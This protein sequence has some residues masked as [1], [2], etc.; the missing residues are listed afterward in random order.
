MLVGRLKPYDLPDPLCRVCLSRDW[1][2]MHLI[3]QAMFLPLTLVTID[4]MQLTHMFWSLTALCNVQLNAIHVVKF[5]R[6][7]NP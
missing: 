2:L 7:Q 1:E 5:A 3:L 4:F 6:Y